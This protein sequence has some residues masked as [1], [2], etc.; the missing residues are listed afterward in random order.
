MTVGA[1]VKGCFY[2]LKQVESQFK[3]L[4]LK[5]TEK[6]AKAAF[7]NAE[8]TIKNVK[9]TMRKQLAYI[10]KEEPQYK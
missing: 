3:L 10:V 4:H 6:E 1:N 8:Q 2:S 7:K 5:T 9:E